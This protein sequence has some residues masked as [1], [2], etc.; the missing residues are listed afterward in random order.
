[1]GPRMAVALTSSRSDRKGALSFRVVIGVFF[2]LM[3]SGLL[4]GLVIHRRYVGFERVVAHHV[5]PDAAFVLRWDVEKVSLF[6]PT[7]RFLLPL[8]DA[9]PAGSPAPAE[10]EGSRRRDRI[11]E[12]TDLQLGR[13]LREALVSFGPGPED[14]ALVLGGS[15]PE[16][17]V[18]SQALPALERDGF[19]SVAAG[20]LQA[21][22]GLSLARASDGAFV[23]A[24]SPARLEVGLA[25]RPL[26]P[27]TPRTG[28]GSLV[29][30]PDR[31]GL[32]KGVRQVLS[33]LG[34]V[35]EV[36]A[37]AE[38]GSPLSLE[39]QVRFR[40][41]PPPDARD[42]IRAAVGAVLLDQ[43]PRL[44]QKFGPLHVESGENRGFRV[45]MLLDDIV[46]EHA[47]GRLSR[48]LADALALRPA[49]N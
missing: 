14:W 17:D 10:P 41:D 11:A 13:D 43:L 23:L 47:V 18:L 32:P 8:F 4:L 35:S 9:H 7:R 22:S 38:W 34:D 26:Q 42:R 30:H 36:R 48:T 29:I 1:M 25:S 28:A 49:H 3:V 5:P 40:G 24:A 46:L 12:R 16:D 31:P 6:E 15:F 33:V 44:E 37:N 27:T 20:R 19:R 2:G 21:P 39:L 45:R